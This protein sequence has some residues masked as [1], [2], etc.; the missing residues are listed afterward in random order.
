MKDV[1]FSCIYPEILRSFKAGL[2]VCFRDALIISIPVPKM[3]IS[4]KVISL[5][6]PFTVI[7]SEV[8]VALDSHENGL[9]SPVDMSLLN[10][11]HL[12]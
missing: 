5:C 10:D 4:Q 8:P 12:L 11:P 9:I 7:S 3:N 1:L 2:K 6:F